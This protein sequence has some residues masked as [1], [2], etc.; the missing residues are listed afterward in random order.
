MKKV[1]LLLVGAALAISLVGCETIKGVGQDIKNTGDNLYDLV[2][3][4]NK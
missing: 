2:K 1:I 3:G 4:N